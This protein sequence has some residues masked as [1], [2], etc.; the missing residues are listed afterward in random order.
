M[1]P[2]GADV[3]LHIAAVDTDADCCGMPHRGAIQRLLSVGRNTAERDDA[4]RW[5]CLFRCVHRIAAKILP[6]L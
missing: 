3:A 5:V 1:I 2:V 4:V 6:L